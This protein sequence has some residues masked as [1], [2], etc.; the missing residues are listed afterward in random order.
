M[1]TN[2]ERPT[3]LARVVEQAGGVNQLARMLGVSPA[4]VAEWRQVPATRVLAVE[5]A[6]GISRHELRP[7]IYSP[8]KLERAQGRKLAPSRAA[9]RTA[10]LALCEAIM[11]DGDYDAWHVA[12]ARNALACPALAA[13]AVATAEVER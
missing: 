12:R 9:L 2:Q 1:R 6:T 10:L 3:L 4:T 8:V 11:A 7:D 13:S 5:A